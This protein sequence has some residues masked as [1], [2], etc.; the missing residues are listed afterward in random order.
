MTVLLLIVFLSIE[1]QIKSVIKTTSQLILNTRLRKR[2]EIQQTVKVLTELVNISQ[3]PV[4]VNGSITIDALP[5]NGSCVTLLRK[6]FIP[7][8]AVIHEWQ[9]GP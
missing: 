3:I 8:D 5:D 4:T 9:D 7:K 1:I 2:N 6:C